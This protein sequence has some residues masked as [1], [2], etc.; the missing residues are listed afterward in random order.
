MKNVFMEYNG[1]DDKYFLPTVS[2]L[3]M[4]AYGSMSQQWLL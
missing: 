3:H 2:W 1:D 4:T